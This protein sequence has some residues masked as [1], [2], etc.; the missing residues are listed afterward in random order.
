MSESLING[1]KIEDTIC[2]FKIKQNYYYALA[3]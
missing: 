1:W 2:L 3:N